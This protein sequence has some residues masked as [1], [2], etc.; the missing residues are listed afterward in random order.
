MK[1]SVIIPIYNAESY[2]ERCLDS[3]CRQTYTDLEIIAV[4]DCTPDCSMD[5]VEQFA[6]KDSRIRVVENP[7]N[8]GAMVARNKGC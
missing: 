1:V 3:V 2:L 6:K 5:I 4:N 7:C 8:M